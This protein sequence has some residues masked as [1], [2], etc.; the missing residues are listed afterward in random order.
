M[1]TRIMILTAMFIFAVAFAVYELWGDWFGFIIF[2]VFQI[3]MLLTINAYFTGKSMSLL[4]SSLVDKDTVGR[5]I[6]FVLAI[7]CYLGLYFLLLLLN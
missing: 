4:G 1:K 2:L 3:Q 5:K 7:L 6:Y